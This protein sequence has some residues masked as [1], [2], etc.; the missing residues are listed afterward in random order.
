MKLHRSVVALGAAAALTLSLPAA[1][2]A[3]PASKAKGK[4]VAA[5]KQA[6]AKAKAAEARKKKDEKKRHEAFPGTVTAVGAG[7]VTISRKVRGVTL[8]RTFHVA[9]GAVVKLEDARV[10][11]AQVQVGDKAVAHLRRVG[12]AVTVVKLNVDRPAAPA[13]P[14]APDTA[15]VGIVI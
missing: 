2:H 4:T 10:S 6:A 12:G 5:Q 13:A 14:A 7:T 11:L 1:A 15:T 9:P 8:A 3:A